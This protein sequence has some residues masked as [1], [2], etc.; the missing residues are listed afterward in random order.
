MMNTGASQKE[1]AKM[2]KKEEEKRFEKQLKGEPRFNYNYY[3]GQNNLAQDCML[4]K[5]DKVKDEAYYAKRIE[6]VRAQ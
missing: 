5:K 6:V 3:N 2:E 4:R 1:V